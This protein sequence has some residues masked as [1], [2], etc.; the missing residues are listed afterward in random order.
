MTRA[1]LESIMEPASEALAKM[2]YLTCEDRC[3]EA[4]GLAKQAGDWSQY[5]RVLLPL[6]EARRQR[7]LIAAEGVIRLGT[8][9]LPGDPM[10]WITRCQA[11][12]VIVT[13]PHD[14]G[15][16]E[17]LIHQTQRQRLY[18]EVL[19]VD[20]QPQAHDW[21]ITALTGIDSRCSVT[22]PPRSWVDRWLQPLGSQGLTRNDVARGQQGVAITPGDWFLNACEALG[23]A[24]LSQ[25]T[26]TLGTLDR[27]EA[28]ERCL[29]AV[30]DHEVLHQ[31]LAAAARAMQGHAITETTSG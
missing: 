8:G 21:M 19:W 29:A 15:V 4:L 1:P 11:G 14:A 16:A 24:A 30:T 2:D 12:C 25:V 3:L 26:S 31:E 17:D 20:N 13:Q 5:A 18:V 22:A 23:D 6:Q 9:G 27:V 7:R 10:D 28:L